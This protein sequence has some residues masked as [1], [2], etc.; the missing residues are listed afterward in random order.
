MRLFPTSF[1]GF[2]LNDHV[3]IDSWFVDP[4]AYSLSSSSVGLIKRSGAFPAFGSIQFSEKTSSIKINLRNPLS[5]RNTLTQRINTSDMVRRTLKELVAFDEDNGIFVY[6][7][8]YPI[9]LICDDDYGQQWT[10]TF[11]IPDS[12][13]RTVKVFSATKTLTATGQTLS[14]TTSGNVPC[15]PIFSITP[16]LQ[17]TG[18]YPYRQYYTIIPRFDD[19][20][21]TYPVEIT[22]GGIDTAALVGAG[23][24]RAD[25]YDLRVF[26]N[27][28]EVNRWF[29]NTGG[30]THVINSAST[31]VWCNLNFPK[32]NSLTLKTAITVTT[33]ITQVVINTPYTVVKK[34]KIYKLTGY[35]TAGILQ[36]DTEQFYYSGIDIKNGTFTITERG[37]RGTTAATHLANVAVT[38]ITNDIQILYGNSTEVAPDID[39][40]CKPV[41]DLDDS[42]NTSWVYK[43]FGSDT[44]PD[45]TGRWNYAVKV[46]DNGNDSDS[47]VHYGASDT[48]ADPFTVMGSDV[49]CYLKNNKWYTATVDIYWNFF[50]PAGITT[51]DSSGYNYRYSASWV[52]SCKLQKQVGTKWT[53]VYSITSPATPAGWVAWTHA[54]AALGGTYKNIRY[55]FSGSVAAQANNWAGNEV[56]QVTLT[57]NGSYTPLCSKSAE[58]GSSYNMDLTISNTATYEGTTIT[59]WIELKMPMALGQSLIMETDSRSVY[60]YGNEVSALSALS[61]SSERLMWLPLYHGTNVLTFTET[62]LASVTVVVAYEERYN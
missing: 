34:K 1:D 58:I 21:N 27:K 23:K 3:E 28:V 14:I 43:Y 18:G 52:Q 2:L 42:T 30:D 38:V 45:M 61:K 7:N 5:Y 12:H 44:Y 25:G 9:S 53:D 47:G 29:P 48:D 13:W 57:L 54:G 35:P 37:S 26:V 10:A 19:D 59:E 22:D 17:K 62:G 55:T 60:I 51:V 20:V 33:A 8:C 16:N 4:F 50:H 15:E 24:M 6:V 46:A 56:R 49:K 40:T 41:L 39:D 11:T 36:I 32:Y 31:K